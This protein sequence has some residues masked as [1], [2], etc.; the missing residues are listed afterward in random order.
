MVETVRPAMPTRLPSFLGYGVF[1][2]LAVVNGRPLLVEEHWANL[3]QAAEALRLPLAAQSPPQAPK[4][5]EGR[6]RWILDAQG[7]RTTF[8]EEKVPRAP[9]RTFRLTRGSVRLGS[10]NWDARHKTLS[11]LSHEQ[12]KA[13]AQAAGADEAILAN[14]R[15]EP[16]TGATAN[17]FWAAQGRL[18][19]PAT[20]SGC[21]GGAVRG[22][23]LNQGLPTRLA[24]H[25]RWRDLE[26]A[27]EIFVTNSLRGIQPATA[28]GARRWPRP[29]PI[30][31][32]LVRRYRHAFLTALR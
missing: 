3:R 8:D 16:V 25:P 20:E 22:W 13:E 23:V 31:Q 32:E 1:E 26:N 15:N 11:Y 24:R 9:R 18:F 14:E 17:L 6:W 5:T 19:T 30:S 4:A 21:R 10:A 2:T 12:A 28:F 27:D 7:I 29:G